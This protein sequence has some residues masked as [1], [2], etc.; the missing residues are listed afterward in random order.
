MVINPIVRLIYTHYYNWV[1]ISKK[2]VLCSP[3]LGEDEPILTHIFQVDSNHQLD[4][5]S[6]VYQQEP[7]SLGIFGR[8]ITPPPP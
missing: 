6:L 2:N 5:D 8:W 3:L 1:V 4:K 7:L